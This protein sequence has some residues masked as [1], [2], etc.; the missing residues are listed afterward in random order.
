M[1]DKKILLIIIVIILY[2]R[3]K[4]IVQSVINFAI[5]PPKPYE[6]YLESSKNGLS[7]TIKKYLK[8][9]GGN[10]IFTLPFEEK[11][12]IIT[13]EYINVN[14]Y[15]IF[16]KKG[17][18]PKLIMEIAL[19]TPKGNSVFLQNY[20]ER[21]SHNYSKMEYMTAMTA[22][23]LILYTNVIRDV[24]KRNIPTLFNRLMI[25]TWLLHFGKEPDYAAIKYMTLFC[26]SFSNF[27]TLLIRQEYISRKAE[28]TRLLIKNIINSTPTSITGVWKSR[29]FFSLEHIA[30]E[31]SH[32]ILAMTIQ[33]LALSRKVLKYP[34]EAQDA[35]YFFQKYAFAPFISSLTNR[36]NGIIQALGCDD[37]KVST[38][39]SVMKNKCPMHGLYSTEAE[40]IV[41]SGYTINVNQ[42]FNAFGYGYRR[43]AGEI[44]TR[45][46]LKEF[47]EIMPKEPINSYPRPGSLWGLNSI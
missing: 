37:G 8:N 42:K 18:V 36:G 13:S 20:N 29:K 27:N 11:G 35:D 6:I 22:E 23:Q 25:L 34:N 46:Y 5:Y 32:N 31:I 41:P 4:Y 2:Y 43:C 3:N 38:I 47:L 39:Q 19:I 12:T 33:W 45:I 7:T 26:K 14:N 17:S 30:V 10:L 15:D 21:G 9:E 16:H 44:L 1:M 40:E 24:L 28:F